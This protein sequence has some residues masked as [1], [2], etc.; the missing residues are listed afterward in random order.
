MGNTKNALHGV[1]TNKNI[2]KR[3]RDWQGQGWCR[4]AVNQLEQPQSTCSNISVTE[5]ACWQT[6]CA[7]YFQQH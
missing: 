5:P 4:L 7:G 6:D 3:G 2:E 1:G